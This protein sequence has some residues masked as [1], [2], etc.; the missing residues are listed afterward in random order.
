MEATVSVI[1]VSKRFGSVLAVDGMSFEVYPGEIFGLL[2]PNGA[3][4]TTTI[5]MMLDIFRPDSGRVEVLGGPW[6]EGKKQRVGYLPE[7]RGL[8]KDQ[9]L[10][11]VITYLATL[12]GLSRDEARDRMEP[13]LERLDLAEHRDKKIDQLSR[14]MQ[15]KAQMIATLLHKPDLIVV[16][17]PFSGLDPVNTRVVKDIILEQAQAG[18]T[19]I[20]STHQMHQV[21]A[22]CNRILLVHRGRRVLYGD[23]RK[24]KQ[25]HS[26][27]ALLIR[28]SGNMERLPGVL[29][30][31]RDNG[32]WHL[33]LS[34]ETDPQEVLRTLTCRDGVRVERFEVAEPSL[35]DIFIDTVQG[36]VPLQAEMANE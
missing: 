2:G 16:D 32:D 31:R 13:W 34:P 15:Q 4:K 17:E 5:R 23:V 36:D 14:G 24:I 27:N 35:E 7:E 10:G 18:R 21:E 11:R 3:G 8:Y 25:N 12:K 33:S 1:E 22:L 29:D 28:G 30:A 26:G 6:S 19:I 20:M 9:L